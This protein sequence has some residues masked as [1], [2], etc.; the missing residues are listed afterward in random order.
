MYVNCSPIALLTSCLVVE[1]TSEPSR[2]KAPVHT[3]TSY[4]SHGGLLVMY[5]HSATTQIIPL[6]HWNKIVEPKPNRQIRP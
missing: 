5:P 3:I 6:Q 1:L 4:G 2:P